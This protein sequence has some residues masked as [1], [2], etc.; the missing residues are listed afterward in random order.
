MRVEP[1][2]IRLDPGTGA[3]P[4]T[5]FPAVDQLLSAPAPFQVNVVG[6]GVTY[7]IMTIPEPPAPPF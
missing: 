2:K 6:E 4:P 1:I 3:T 7:R 5:Q